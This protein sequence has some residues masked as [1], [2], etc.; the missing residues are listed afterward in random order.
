LRTALQTA[1]D[2]AALAATK[3]PTAPQAARQPLATSVALASLGAS[4]IE[5]RIAT[6]GQLTIEIS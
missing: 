2:S 4:V 1:V 5:F 3:N 6:P